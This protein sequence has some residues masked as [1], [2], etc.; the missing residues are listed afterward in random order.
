MIVSDGDLHD[1]AEKLNG[2]AEALEGV[3]TNVAA[4]TGT[5]NG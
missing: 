2:A 5:T 1:A 4:R 3:T